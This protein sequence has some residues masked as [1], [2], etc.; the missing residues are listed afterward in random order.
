M[1]SKNTAPRG[2]KREDGQPKNGPGDDLPGR[3][4]GLEK[5]RTYG[6]MTPADIAA[7]DRTIKSLKEKLLYLQEQKSK[8]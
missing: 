8:D 3:I 6:G 4:L 2:F 7:L 1:D 5:A